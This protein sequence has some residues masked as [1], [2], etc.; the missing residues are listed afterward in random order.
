MPRPDPG[1]VTVK[2]VVNAF[3]NDKQAL[4][5]VSD[6]SSRTWIDYKDACDLL[7]AQVGK[8][9]AFSNLAPDDFAALRN[10]LAER[11]GPYRLK[12]TIQ[13]IRPVGKYAYDSRMIDRPV[14]FGPVVQAAVEEDDVVA[15]G[16]AGAEPSTPPMRSAA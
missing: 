2:E 13:C 14:V 7:I 1:A 12:K 5:G 4:R 8:S 6:L 3:L 9:R 16:R 15:P 11:W 10:K